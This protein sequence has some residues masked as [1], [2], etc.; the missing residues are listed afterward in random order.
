MMIQ[1]DKTMEN[2]LSSA[3]LQQRIKDLSTIFD[4]VRVVDPSSQHQIIYHDDGTARMAQ[5]YCFGLW[6]RSERCAN[7]ISARALST[8]QRTT[9]FEFTDDHT[10]LL[11]ATYL[12][13]DQHPCVLECMLELNDATLL[14]AYVKSEFISR[15][16]WYTN[17]LYN[18]S[19]T[20]V[21]NRRYYDDQIS[22]LTVQAA[23]MLD[24]DH[25]KD[26]NDTWRHKAGDIALQAVVKAV[27]SCIRK[28]D[29]L[30]RYG[31]DE[32]VIA[33]TEISPE[34]FARKLQTICTA[35]EAAVV[36]EYPDIRLTISVGGVYGKG[37]LK[38]KVEAADKVLYEAKQQRNHVIVK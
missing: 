21:R 20:G 6:S 24:I 29:I 1:T 13:V 28:S 9:K 19:L 37:Q 14:G 27:A 7:C 12:E 11:A 38:E 16:T 36:P 23:A 3:E 25:F 17:Q 5:D 10:Y 31:G 30:L 26:I 34:I 2:R 32:F 4:M 8:G 18:D 35:V 22:G 33:F 15:L